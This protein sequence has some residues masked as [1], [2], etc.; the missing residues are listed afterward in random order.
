MTRVIDFEC[1]APA[2]LS[3]PDYHAIERGRPNT[4]FPEPLERPEGY[5]FANY[6]HVFQE[7]SIQRPSVKAAPDDGGMEKLVADMDRAGIEAGLLV[8]TRNSSIAQIHQVLSSWERGPQDIVVATPN[9]TTQYCGTSPQF[10]STVPSSRRITHGVTVSPDTRF[11]FVSVEGVGG[12]PGTV[13]VIDLQTFERR[14]SIDVGKQAS[15]ID[16]WKME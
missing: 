16:F 11:A 2:S 15:E 3:D 8:G 13:D 12:E 1:Y 7:S 9:L 10:D 6:E 4:P 14:A 5:G